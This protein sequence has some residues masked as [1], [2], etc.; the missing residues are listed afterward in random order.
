MN[1]VEWEIIDRGNFGSIKLGMTKLEINTILGEAFTRTN[2]PY[3]GMVRD[4]YG[5]KMQSLTILNKI[6]NFGQLILKYP[7][8]S[9]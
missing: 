8:Q 3:T 6:A 1:K 7:T 4:A 5:K 9:K 2:T